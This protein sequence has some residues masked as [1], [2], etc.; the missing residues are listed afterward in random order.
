LA[1]YSEGDKVTFAMPILLRGQAVGAVEWEVLRSAYT[2]NTRLLATE[3]V[4]RLAL[5]A[6][7][8]RLKAAFARVL[9]IPA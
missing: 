7:N 6:D 9:P 4:A 2:E 5:A 1:E 3:L 8:A